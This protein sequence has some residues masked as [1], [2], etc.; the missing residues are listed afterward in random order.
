MNLKEYKRMALGNATEDKI[1]RFGLLYPLVDK[2]ERRNALKLWDD[3]E[4]KTSKRTT[5]KQLI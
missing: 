1:K 4:D 2:S 3:F 5:G